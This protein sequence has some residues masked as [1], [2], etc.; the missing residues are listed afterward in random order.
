MIDGIQ[1]TF[2][3][4][5]PKTHLLGL[6][7]WEVLVNEKSGQR[8]NEIR[9]TKVR[10]LDIKLK[11]SMNGGYNLLVNGSFHKF[12]NYGEHNA[13]QFAF[14]K[15]MQSIDSFTDLFEVDAGECKLHGLEIGV[16]IPLPYSPLR[17]LKNLVC[18]RAKAFAQINKNNVRKGLQCSL[19]QYTV[20]VYDKEKQSGIDC[21]NVLRFEIAIS[22][23]QAVKKYN[24]ATLADLQNP[25]K[26]YPLVELLTEAVQDIIW[27]DGSV[28]LDRLTSREQKQWLSF[29][30]PNVWA[31][32]GKYQ[33]KR[34]LRTWQNLLARYANLPALLPLVL[35][36]WNKL[37]SGEFEAD[38]QPPFY[39]L[40]GKAEALEAAT[41]LP[42]ECTVKKLRYN[43]KNTIPSITGFPIQENENIT[44]T[45][46]NPLYEAKKHCAT[47]GRDISK[48]HKRTVFCSE[49]LYGKAAKK[50]RNTDS[51]KRRNKKVK[52]RKA[53]GENTYLAITYLDESGNAYTDILHPSEVK[54]TKEWLNR[55]LSVEIA[56]Q[57]QRTLM[58]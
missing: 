41:F 58:R 35:D 33:R 46:L 39:Q 45:N 23:M 57:P 11:P 30:N 9:C 38:K 4:A 53:M 22:K 17:V 12:H 51:N 18:F 52:I 50:C 3:T 55:I 37:F 19:S 10:A 7:C 13:D 31:S 43:P 1:F 47:C 6:P 8:V 20:K 32:M 26:V 28:N 15:L 2:N 49:T 16:N 48:Q 25:A 54:T 44:T 5:D 56:G 14:A 29:S 36:T 27:T 34:A 24:L 21:G 42:L 40:Q